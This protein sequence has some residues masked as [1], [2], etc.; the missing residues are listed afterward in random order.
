MDFD[1]PNSSSS[2]VVP[3][4]HRPEPKE[5]VAKFVCQVS[6]SDLCSNPKLQP[7]PGHRNHFT[8]YC[9]PPRPGVLR[10]CGRQVLVG[11]L[12]RRGY[13]PD[14][15]PTVESLAGAADHKLFVSIAGN[16]HHVLRR[17]YTMRKSPLVTTCTPGLITFYSLKRTIETL[18]PDPYMLNSKLRIFLF[19]LN[20]LCQFV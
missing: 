7:T 9:T 16:P 17:H 20:F 14:G 19:N 2:E 4:V 1:G 13:L 10:F 18:S 6:K 3:I 11:R 15:F 5:R 12:R 8:T